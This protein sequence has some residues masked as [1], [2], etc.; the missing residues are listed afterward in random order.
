MSETQNEKAK[1]I[2]SIAVENYSD[3]NSFLM[4]EVTFKEKDYTVYPSDI[5]NNE[6]K[7]T[8]AFRYIG[9][10]DRYFDIYEKTLKH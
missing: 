3:I 10:R 6:D 1:K 2:V 8:L 7:T 9:C 5:S 4:A